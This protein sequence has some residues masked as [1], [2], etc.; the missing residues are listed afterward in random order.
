[1]SKSDDIVARGNELRKCRDCLA[2][3]M[4]YLLLL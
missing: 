1:M 3:G 4:D 2:E